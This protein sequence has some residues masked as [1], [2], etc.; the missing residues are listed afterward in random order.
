VNRLSAVRLTE[1][2]GE[3]SD[4]ER[5]IV[6]A[7]VR[8]HLLS[9]TQVERLFFA[10]IA[11]PAS[12]ARLARRTLA[13]LV[14]L[15]LL[16]RLERRIGGIRAG[17]AGHV[18]HPTAG[19]QRLVAYW[20]GEGLKRP[21]SHYEPSRSF[22]R[23]GLGI[24]E[25][26]VRLVEADRAGSTELLEFQTEPAAWLAFLGPGGTRQIL[27]P[28]AFVR[29][30]VSAEEEARFY[31]EIDCG[32]EGRAA[33]AR[34]CRVYLDAWQAGAGDRVFPRVAWVATTERR[35]TLLT[36]VCASLPAEAWKLFVVTTPERALAVLT[37]TA[38]EVQS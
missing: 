28:D 5:L 3:L 34:K 36:E 20:H 37:G 22:V 6:E 21:R 15:R 7:V 13:R 38:Q 8:L 2:A 1:L 24:S 31:L 26:Y 23:H 32:T 30:G 4:R 12:R 35:V 29:L 18:Y 33:L 11:N 17:A 14:E 19:A 10:A 27:K 16:G 25:S 9:G